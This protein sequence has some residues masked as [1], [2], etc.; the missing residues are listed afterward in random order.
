MTYF[1]LIINEYQYLVSK[2]SEKIQDGVSYICPYDRAFEFVK[3]FLASDDLSYERYWIYTGWHLGIIFIFGV[4]CYWGLR[5]RSM[6][7][8]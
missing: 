2:A 8:Y 4:V 1:N 3:K 6:Q 7:K 5:K